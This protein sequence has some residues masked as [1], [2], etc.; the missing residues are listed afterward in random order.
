MKKLTTAHLRVV[1]TAFVALSGASGCGGE[2]RYPVEGSVTLEGQPLTK[3]DVVFFADDGKVIPSNLQ[4]TGKI[5]SNGR[6]RMLSGG[7]AGIPPGK[8]RVTVVAQTSERPAKAPANPT[9]TY[10]LINQKYFSSHSSPLRV[11]VVESPR[12]DAYD[13]RLEK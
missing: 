3:G 11:E 7:A 9:N 6:F 4:P 12:P 8:Y 10:A 2:K 5:D 1:L 13:L